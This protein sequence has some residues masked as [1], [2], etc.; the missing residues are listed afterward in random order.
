M[1][2]LREVSRIKKNGDE[3]KIYLSP[4]IFAYSETISW[5]GQLIAIA[6]Q[7]CIAQFGPVKHQI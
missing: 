3:F 5:A 4:I 6:Q 2:Q 1:E 7:F